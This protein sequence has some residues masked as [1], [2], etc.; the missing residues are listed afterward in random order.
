MIPDELKKDYPNISDC[1]VGM[2]SLFDIHHIANVEVER[3]CRK[4]MDRHL[5]DFH[6]NKTD[7]VI[8]H[9]PDEEPENNRQTLLHIR[10]D[11][12]G[13]QDFKNFCIINYTIDK[14][15]E[16]KDSSNPIIE[17]AYIDDLLKCRK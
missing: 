15:R 8:W 10:I 4:Y 2:W 14:F 17:W 7:G 13:T 12:K 3:V 16:Q 5:N 11:I 6:Y 1:E 9:T